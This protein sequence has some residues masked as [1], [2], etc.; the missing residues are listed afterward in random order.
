LLRPGVT[1]IV[2]IENCSAISR[3]PSYLCIS[4]KQGAQV[5]AGIALNLT[6]TRSTVGT[7]NDATVMAYGDTSIYVDKMDRIEAAGLSGI[8]A[9][10]CATIT[11]LNYDAG[12]TN[13][14]YVVHVEYG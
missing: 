14:P 10:C 6:P 12:V 11:A 3:S 1:T 13:G 4:E 9:P 5:H 2:G 7:A 8:L